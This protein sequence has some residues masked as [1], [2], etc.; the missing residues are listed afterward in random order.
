[1]DCKLCHSAYLQEISMKKLMTAMFLAT[2]LATPFTQ[3]LKAQDM[4]YY[5]KAY[6]VKVEDDLAARQVIARLNHA[7]DA[8]DYDAYG[9]LFA[10]DGVFVSGFGNAVGPKEVA[11][12][13]VKV[14]P[15]ITNKRHVAANHVIHSNGD[16]LVVTTYLI[17]FERAS[18][19]KYVGSALNIDTLKK[20]DGS[21]RVARHE[22][23]LDPAT[24]AYIQSLMKNPQ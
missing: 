12:A 18:E 16:E 15:F 6:D 23:T 11:A 3:T 9:N 5:A 13:L 20:V 2:V 22:S 24:Q 4:T 19:L 21:W 10:P 14:S 8:A 1:M 17:V 7:L